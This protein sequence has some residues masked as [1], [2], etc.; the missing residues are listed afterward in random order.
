M[1]YDYRLH[2]IELWKK[3]WFRVLF[4]IALWSS[5][6]LLYA[7]QLYIAYERRT[8]V[9][10]LTWDQA[11]TRE[12]S[13]W[14]VWAILSPLI[15]LLSSKF[16]IGFSK[17]LR[18]ITIHIVAASLFTVVHLLLYIILIW[19]LDVSILVNHAASGTTSLLTN[20][21]YSIVIM[22]FNTRYVIYWIILFLSHAIYYYRRFR[23]GERIAMELRTRLAEEQLRALKFQLHPHFLFNTLNAI[24]SL[25]HKDVSAAEKMVT[26][27]SDFLRTTLDKVGAEEVSLKEELEMLQNYLEIEQV[28]FGDHLKIVYDIN[29]NVYDALVPNLLLQPIVENAITHGIA[30]S[31]EGGRI[32][33]RALPEN[34]QLFISVADTGRGIHASSMEDIH[35]GVGLTNTRIR[36]QQL[37]GDN[38]NLLLSNTEGKGVTVIIHIPYRPSIPHEPQQRRT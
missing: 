25:M 6:T 34:G 35:S 38:Y 15:F 26:R 1:D 36:L 7:I 17:W 13:Y 22:N 9:K 12:F 14:S 28:R 11:L 10:V 21:T 29:E 27:L 37:Y 3:K 8:D 33:I 19:L 2:I 16:R 30:K 23:E 24:S 5:L 4:F 18:N 32:V 31:K 20:L